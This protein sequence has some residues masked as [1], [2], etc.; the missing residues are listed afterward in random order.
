[1]EAAV[2]PAETGK[3]VM[4]R[5][6]G[7]WGRNMEYNRSRRKFWTARYAVIN[8]TYFMGFCGVHAYASIFM[9]ERGFTNSRIGLLLALANVFSVVMQPIIA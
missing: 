5:N 3:I 1:M 4:E 9:L 6:R 2:P 7:T 8:A